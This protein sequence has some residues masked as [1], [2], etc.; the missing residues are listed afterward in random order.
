MG[1]HSLLS[2]SKAERWVSCPASVAECAHLPEQT[3]EYAKEGTL[4]HEI[5]AK[6]LTSIMEDSPEKYEKVKEGC[7]CAHDPEMVD[8]V[9]NYTE[10][11]RSMAEGCFAFGI[12][13]PLDLSAVLN[14]P[15]EKGT[16]DLYA[17]VDGDPFELQVHDLKYG[18]M[19]VD[20]EKNIQLIEYALG[21]VD[22][23]SSRYDISK[24]LL[25]IHQP[26]LHH[27]S[28]WAISVE[29]L[30]NWRGVL[31][32]KA[33]TCMALFEGTS[34]VRPDH[35]APGEKQCRFCRAKPTC[36][37][38]REFVEK[39]LSADF[40]EETEVVSEEIKTQTAHPEQLDGV[41]KCL[42]H[43]SLIRL[44]C[45][46]VEDYSRTALLNGE[47]IPGWKL[48]IGRKPAGKWIS[49]E[50][51]LKVVFAQ[52]RGKTLVTQKVISPAQVKKALKNKPKAWEGLQQ[53]IT[54]AEPKPSMVNDTSKGVPWE[55]EKVTTEEFADEDTPATPVAKKEE[56]SVDS[57]YKPIVDN[58]FSDLY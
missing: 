57:N 13:E 5:A 10:V 43:V 25:V 39:D 44:W 34:P 35:Y 26:R 28:E 47:K 51:I 31:R 58:D 16:A 20:A 14:V 53:Y 54:H 33:R 42:G 4:A 27:I 56:S 24:V 32:E 8:K 38:L 6:L 36:K 15:G 52:R 55:T 46:A 2:P 19:R 3:S 41:A 18:M 9:L 30:Y 12:E 49:E 45:N 40:D 23:L 7:Y 50:E 22:K 1:D 21:V 11:A 37:S 17:V 29:E 48:I